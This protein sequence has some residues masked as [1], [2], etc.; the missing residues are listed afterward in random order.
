MSSN[1]KECFRVTLENIIHPFT[2]AEILTYLAPL[3]Q[4]GEGDNVFFN[5][6]FFS[7]NVHLISLFFAK[8]SGDGKE[9]CTVTL[10]D[11]YGRHFLNDDFS[12]ALL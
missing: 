5:A 4:E 7:V 2:A 3:D 6:S 1:S 12:A 10:M 8:Q 11:I 9:F